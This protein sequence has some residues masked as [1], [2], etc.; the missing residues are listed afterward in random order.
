MTRKQDPA[1]RRHRVIPVWRRELDREG[2]ARALLLLAMHLDETTP[3]PHRK[4][5]NPD[6]NSTGQKGSGR[7]EQE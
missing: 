1:A 5:Q 7:D 3:M 6:E 2:F 4:R